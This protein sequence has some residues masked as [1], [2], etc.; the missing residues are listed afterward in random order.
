MSGAASLQRLLAASAA[1]HGPRTAVVDAAGVAVTYAELDRLSDGLR[2]RLVH[3]GVRPG[4][5]V[6]LYLH[7]SVDSIVAI[8]GILKAGAAY[9]PVDP[10]APVE[11]SAFILDNC[12][13]RVVI[14]EEAL[15]APLLAAL[16]HAGETPVMLGIDRSGPD[17]VP[18]RELLD[19]LE[20]DE[21]RKSVV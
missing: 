6:G 11:R 8:F 20:R 18:I 19:R 1:D 9:V 13:V 15:A 16:P 5:R 10:D 17:P 14:T 12:S 7:K 21:D 2:D 3:L 4:D